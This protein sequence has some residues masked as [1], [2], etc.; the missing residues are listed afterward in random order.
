MR[1][2]YGSVLV[3][4]GDYQSAIEQFL[5]IRS[6][7][8]DQGNVYSRIMGSSVQWAIALYRLGRHTEAVIEIDPV[9]SQRRSVFGEDHYETAEAS[10]IKA[11]ALLM[12]GN[13]PVARAMFE[14]AIPVL[15]EK[16]FS[17]R[18]IGKGLGSRASKL[19]LIFEAYFQ[20]KVG[21]IDHTNNLTRKIE[22]ASELFQL[23]E[24]ARG[25]SVTAALRAGVVR[26]RAGNT[27]LSGLVRQSQDFD[28]QLNALHEALSSAAVHARA[29]IPDIR[30]RIEKILTAQNATVAEIREK[31]PDYDRLI[32]PQKPS[33]S[34]VAQ[35]LHENEALLAIFAGETNSYVW[36][37]PK[38]GSVSFAVVP[39]GR[40]E[41]KNQVGL[42]RRSLDPNA[43]YLKEIPE[44]RL[45]LAHELYTDFLHPV[46]SGWEDASELILIADGALAQLPFSLLLTEPPKDTS[47]AEILFGEYQDQPW[48]LRRASISRLPSV[49]SLVALRSVSRQSNFG[50]PFIGFG[51]PYFSADQLEIASKPEA[52][53]S[54]KSIVSRGSLGVAQGKI[55]LRNAPDVLF[56]KSAE[57]ADLPRLPDTGTEIFE[58]ARVLKA[59]TSQSVFLGLRATE[60]NVKS[61]PLDEFGVV[62]FATHGLIP[63]DLDGLHQPALALSSPSLSSTD[64]D[65]LLIMSEVLD[66][67]LNASWV[68]LSGC[69]TGAGH[70]VGAE[71]FSGLGRAFFFAGAR[72]VLLSNWPVETTSA[73]ALTTAV[74][75]R[76]AADPKLTNS[77]ALRQSMLTLIDGPGFRDQETGQRVFSYAHPIFWAPFTVVGEGAVDGEYATA[78]A[79][80]DAESEEIRER[81][82][83]LV[84]QT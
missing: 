50:A 60:H 20:L 33:L 19:K 2:A 77:A 8:Q 59:G 72:S 28:R 55:T 37:I 15:A 52:A 64:G 3:A 76:Q 40:A 38:S 1:R 84:W 82:V 22:L 81:G 32:N 80:S 57:L 74:F 67:K 68:V 48:L 54:H 66:L 39:K 41:L 36:A 83:G 5:L 18:G 63:G 9:I 10:G 27:E 71:A 47:T 44:F 78:V 42:L 21:E 4:Q 61:L 51:D 29:Q 70:G 62:A 34:D 26:E 17:A 31:F 13:I 43:S 35:S 79:S 75:S 69:N 6:G 7:L 24:L 56:R 12:Q 65:G 30:Q 73:S 53:E 58:I 46:R 14:S 23:A 11:A 49:D 25:Q 45:A 16:F